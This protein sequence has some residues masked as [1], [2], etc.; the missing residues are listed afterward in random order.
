MR[1]FEFEAE[2]YET[3]S[4]VPMTVREKLDRAAIKIS[5]QQWLALELSERQM[6]RELPVDTDQQLSELSALINRFVRERCGATPSMMSSEQQLAAF[7]SLELPTNL[8]ANARALGLELSQDC[9]ALLNQGRTLCLDEIGRRASRQ[10]QFRG[11]PERIP[12]RRQGGFL[13]FA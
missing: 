10:A 11:S 8:A 5:H 12:A 1:R 9:W 6:I 3:L 4:C 13:F 7:P 2:M